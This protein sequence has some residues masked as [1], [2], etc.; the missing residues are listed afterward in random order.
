V[1]LYSVTKRTISPQYLKWQTH[2]L[3]DTK[4]N[5]PPPLE[6]KHKR[7]QKTSQKIHR[8]LP[9]PPLL[10]PANIGDRKQLQGAAWARKQKLTP[11]KKYNRDQKAVMMNEETA[12]ELKSKK[13]LDDMAAPKLLPRSLTFPKVLHKKT[14]NPKSLPHPPIVSNS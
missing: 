2:P 9:S 3:H 8:N 10:P 1:G 6:Y 4:R 14:H 7:E 12:P 5:T 11:A 13:G